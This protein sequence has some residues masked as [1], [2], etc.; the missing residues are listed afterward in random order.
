MI[1]AVA[2]AFL[3]EAIREAGLVACRAVVLA[4]LRAEGLNGV[5]EGRPND[6]QA[7]AHAFGI[8]GQVH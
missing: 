8:P 5:A 4:D 6:F 2:L 3:Q 1:P 7:L